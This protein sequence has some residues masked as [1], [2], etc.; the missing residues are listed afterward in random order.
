MRRGMGK[1]PLLTVPPLACPA[2]MITDTYA[3]FGDERGKEIGVPQSLVL[4]VCRTLPCTRIY[5]TASCECVPP[6]QGSAVHPS[7]RGFLERQAHVLHDVLCDPVEPHASG[8][9]VVFLIFV[10]SLASSRPFSPL[11]AALY[12]TSF[13][14]C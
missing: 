8:L 1:V 7:E 11:N 4:C 14:V 6:L 13:F 3:N 12:R 9:C 5:A 10:M 2:I